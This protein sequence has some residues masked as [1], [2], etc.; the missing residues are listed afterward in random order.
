MQNHPYFITDK[1]IVLAHRGGTDPTENTI[2]AIAN[3]LKA[4]TDVIETDIRATKDG[5]AVLF[6]DDTIERL[7]GQNLRVEDL[8]WS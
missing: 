8:D 4:G 5:V 2:E 1:L 3:A 6:H 7:T